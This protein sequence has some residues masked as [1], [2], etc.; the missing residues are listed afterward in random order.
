M[1]FFK[2]IAELKL[3]DAIKL[4]LTARCAMK[5]AFRQQR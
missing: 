2:L 5:G 1:P 4:S 3:G